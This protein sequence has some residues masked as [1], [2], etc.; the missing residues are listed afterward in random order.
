VP[1]FGETGQPDVDQ[2][3]SLWAGEV[4]SLS[5]G[6]LRMNLLDIDFTD[7]VL[8]SLY[9][10][11][12]QNPMPFYE[13]AWAPDYPDPTDYMVAMFQPD[14]SYTHADAL[15]EQLENAPNYGVTAYNATSCRSYTDVG[16][17]STR[18]STPGGVVSSCQGTAYAAMS[19]LMK[20]AAHLAIGPQ[21]VLDY[22]M[23]E[24]IA[25]AL[26][27]YVY[28]GQQNIVVSYGPWMSGSWFNSNVTIG[29][30]EDQTWYTIPA[31]A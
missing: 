24:R 10:G 2:R 17:W 31:S 22:N 12:G 21:R 7:L 3:L 14:G 19:L 15:S 11:P 28:W 4:S 27:L 20:T 18:A 30:G 13:L 29:G 1:F 5:H 25:S 6:A 8:N 16:Y 26:A 9:N 23:A